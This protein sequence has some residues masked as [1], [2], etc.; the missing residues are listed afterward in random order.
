MGLFINVHEYVYDAMTPV[1]ERRPNIQS[2]Y[3]PNYLV[4]RCK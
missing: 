1:D 2:D 3:V 4:I